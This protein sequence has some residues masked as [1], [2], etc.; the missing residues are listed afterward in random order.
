MENEVVATNGGEGLSQDEAEKLLAGFDP[1]YQSKKQDFVSEEQES[2]LTHILT[3]PDEIDAL[4]DDVADAMYAEGNR[5]FCKGGYDY[6][7]PNSTHDAEGKL[8]E[9]VVNAQTRQW[10]S[11]AGLKQM[12]HDIVYMNAAFQ[13]V[14]ALG[15]LLNGQHGKRIGM[16]AE[17]YAS[18]TFREKAKA[19]KDNGV[20]KTTQGWKAGMANWWDSWDLY[21]STHGKQA[22]DK[23]NLL[24]Y[25]PEADVSYESCRWDWNDVDSEVQK[26]ITDEAV[27]EAVKFGFHSQRKNP[28]TGAI[29]KTDVDYK[30]ANAFAEAVWNSPNHV[31]KSQTGDIFS[32][33][34]S[35]GGYK[36]ELA[37]G[38]ETE[39][40]YRVCGIAESQNVNERNALNAIAMRNMFNTN[41]ELL[42]WYRQYDNSRKDNALGMFNRK[43]DVTKLL[44]DFMEDFR[45]YAK[46]D[47]ELT[48]E[49]IE[50]RDRKQLTFQQL[51]ECLAMDDHREGFRHM[52]G[53]MSRFF[54]GVGNTVLEFGYELGGLFSNSVHGYGK[55]FDAAFS[56][57]SKKSYFDRFKEWAEEDLRCVTA[58]EIYDQ[59]TVAGFIG[60]EAAKLF[61]FS[62]L[63]KA[64]TAGALVNTA[65]KGVNASGRALKLAG[66]EGFG[67][68]VK[69][70]GA[71]I[72]KFGRAAG[73]G[74]TVAMKDGTKGIVGFRKI[75]IPKNGKLPKGAVKIGEDYFVKDIQKV[76][77]GNF[78]Q[79]HNARAA[80]FEKD[81]ENAVAQRKE[82][83][84]QLG[85]KIGD[86]AALDEAF[87]KV[88][89]DIDKMESEIAKSVGSHYGAASQWVADIVNELPSVMTVSAA[90]YDSHLATGAYKIG[91]GFIKYDENGNPVRAKF[92]PDE[93]D[94]V[95]EYSV[96]DAAGNAVFLFKL[97]KLMKGI[98]DGRL[99]TQRIQQSFRNW[100]GKVMELQQRGEYNM[101]SGL[102]AM[103]DN[104]FR[105][106]GAEAAHLFA[107]GAGM[108]VTSTIVGN[109]EDI[110]LKRLRDP[111]YQASIQEY[112][113]QP[114]QAL[115]VLKSGFGMMVGG[116]AAGAL[117][118]AAGEVK[119]GQV[120]LLTKFNQL[121]QMKELDALTRDTWAIAA[122]IAHRKGKNGIKYD[123]LSTDPV[124]ATRQAREQMM[125]D[126]EAYRYVSD[127]TTKFISRVITSEAARL[128]GLKPT[129]GIDIIREDMRKEFGETYVRV[130]DGIMEHV[131]RVNP[132]RAEFGYEWM[133]QNLENQVRTR[134]EA[135]FAEF[136]KHA[137]ETM[138]GIE[139]ALGV[140]GRR[141]KMRGDGSFLLN[142]DVD[143]K[144]GWL[145]LEFKS[146]DTMKAAKIADGQF[147]KGWAADVMNGL[148]GKDETFD[149]EHYGDLK[150]EVAALD[151]TLQE[152][153]K[154]GSDHNGI[155]ERAY[156]RICDLGSN[157]GFF[158]V[159]ADGKKLATMSNT[160]GKLTIADFA[161]ETVHGIIET[162]RDRGYFKAKDGSD[163]EQ[164]L[165]EKYGDAW[166][167]DFIRDL[168]T[169]RQE[170]EANALARDGISKLDEGGAFS[171][172]LN[173]INKVVMLPSELISASRPKRSYVESA[174][175]KFIEDAKTAHQEAVIDEKATEIGEEIGENTPKAEA[176]GGPIVVST[177]PVPNEIFVGG[178]KG[179]ELEARKR[180]LNNSGFYYDS[181]H[182]VW[183]N[184]KSAPTLYHRAVNEAIAVKFQTRREKN[185][186]LF[187]LWREIEGGKLQKEAKVIAI[188]RVKELIRPEEFTKAERDH[189]GILVSE[190]GS[191]IGIVNSNDGIVIDGNS[192][193]PIDGTS[194]PRG[195]KILPYSHDMYNR[196]SVKAIAKTSKMIAAH[197]LPPEYAIKM[198][199]E[200]S[201]AG[202]SLGVQ[203]KGQLHN[204]PFGIVTFMFGKKSID[205]KA[206]DDKGRYLNYLFDRDMGLPVFGDIYNVDKNGNVVRNRMQGTND[207][208]ADAMNDDGSLV[209]YDTNEKVGEGFATWMDYDYE[210][211][212]SK[213]G[214]KAR[215]KNIEKLRAMIDE[216]GNLSAD[217]DLVEF[218]REGE[219]PYLY[220]EGK[221]ARLVSSGEI[222]GV[223]I[224][225][226][227]E[228][229]KAKHTKSVEELDKKEVARVARK[230]GVGVDLFETLLKK[231]LHGGEYLSEE[232]E[233]K[234]LHEIVVK[235]VNSQDDFFSALDKVA[236]L[237]EKNG[238]PVDYWNGDNSDFTKVVRGGGLEEQK[239][240][241]ESVDR[242][243]SVNQDILFN[244]VGMRGAARYFGPK[245]NEVMDGIRQV[246]EDAVVATDDGTRAGLK[247]S[248]N[249]N[250]N[251]WL[252]SRA[253]NNFGPFVLH[254]GGTDGDK[255]PRLEYAGKKPK[256]PQAFLKRAKDGEAF[257][258]YDIMGNAV[259]QDEVLAKAYP[260]IMNAEVVF[261]GTKG[262]KEPAWLDD[263][264]FILAN[265]DGKIVINRDRYDEFLAPEQFAQSLVGLIQKAEG[266]E[267]RLRESDVK[268]A[269]A[270]QPT[271]AKR[272]NSR[273]SFWL[274]DP[275]FIAT[276]KEGERIIPVAGKLVER[277][278]RERLGDKYDDAV[279]RKVGSVI[280]E[281]IKNSVK[282]FAGE[283]EAKFLASRYGMKAEQ[284]M[285][286]SEAEKV[287]RD[288]LVTLDSDLT[289]VQ[290]TKKNIAY[291]ENVIG[292]A[293]DLCLFGKKRNDLT[294]KDRKR[295][296]TIRP[297]LR[298]AIADEMTEAIIERI[299]EGTRAVRTQTEAQMSGVGVG[300]KAERV[301]N[302]NEAGAYRGEEVD[303]S[304]S[305]SEESTAG[306]LAT[307][308]AMMS[309]EAAWDESSGGRTLATSGM[310]VVSSV[311]AGMTSAAKSIDAKWERN[312][313]AVAK[314][315]AD[316]IAKI[317]ETLRKDPSK[318]AS[319][320]SKLMDKLNGLVAENCSTYDPVVQKSMLNEAISMCGS[321]FRVVGSRR[322]PQE[323]TVQAASVKLA[324]EFMA[325]RRDNAVEKVQKWVEEQSYRIGIINAKRTAFVRD[326]MVAAVPVAERLTA[327]FK[328]T[329]DDVSL[330]RESERETAV[331]T[332]TDKILRGAV[333]G[334][335]L[336]S[337][338][339]DAASR[340]VSEAK[341]IQV[342]EVKNARGM[343]LNELNGLL[344]GDIVK[345]IESIGT[346]FGDGNALATKAIK[347]FSDKLR[348]TDSRFLDM[349]EDEF[350]QSE[351]ARAELASTVAAWLQ[352][353]SRRLGW[354]QVREWSMREA[355]RLQKTPQTFASIHMTMAKHAD[356]L[357]SSIGQESV[358]KL[359]DEVD[360][361]IDKYADGDRVAAM[362]VPN[363]DRKVA[364]RLQDYWKYVKQVMRMTEAAVEKEIAK[365]NNEL[366][367]S[368]MQLL[369]LGEK[370]ANDIEAAEEG[371]IARD[372][373]MMRLNALTRFGAMKHKSYAE[374]RDIID[375]QLTHD[376]AGS[377]QRQMILKNAR[378]E[379]DARVRQALIGELT[380]IRNAKKGKFDLPD[381]GTAGGNML[382]FSVAD[383][384]KRMQIYLHEGT[385]AWNFIDQFRQDMSLANIDKTMFVSNW[386]GEMR[387]ACQQIYGVNFERL[388]SDMMV[389][390]PAYDEFSRSGWYIPENGETVEVNVAGRVKKVVLAKQGDGSVK[391]NL[392]NH[393]SK[394]NLIY[395]YAACQ[396][397]DMQVNNAIWGR[398]AEYLR[399]IE[400]IIGPEGV[401]MAGWLTKAYGEIRK[402]I[403][404]I[405]EEITGMPVLSPDERYCPLSFTQDQVSNDERRFS[406]SPYPAF[407]TRRVTHD[408][409]RL[410]EQ[411]DAFRMFEDKIQDAGHYLG[412]AK[413][414]DRMNTTLKHP[415]VQTAFA[416]LYGTKA[417]NDIYAQLADALNGGRKNS[418]T[419]L[420]GV[421]NFVTATS[422]FGN[423]GS[424]MKQLEGIGGWAV[425]M[426]VGEWVRGLVRNPATSRE[427]RDGLRELIEAGLFQTREEEGIS[428]AMVSLMN[429]CDGVPAG[430]MSKT[431]RWY[432]RHGM[433]VTKFV[434]KIAS[435]SMAGQYYVGRKNFYI[436]NGVR[437][438]DAKRKALA[439]TDYAIQTTQQ[440]G[441]PEFLH[442]AQ[443]AGT[444]G[445]MLTQFSGPAFVRWGI[446]CET[447]HRAVV[448]GDKGAW[449]RLA[450]RLIALHLICPS[451]LTL[452]GGISSVIFRR[453]DQ[454]M[455][456][457]VDQTKKNIVANCITGP[458]SGWFIWGQII[459]AF[460]YENVMPDVKGM[461]SKTHFEAPV[462]SK[463]HSLQQMTSKMYK[464]V[465]KAAPWDRFTK[466]ERNLIR[467][468]TWRIFQM[469]FPVT[470]TA[471]ALNMVK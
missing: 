5:I 84:A 166:E 370:D 451:I 358:N 152:L 48:P 282:D 154:N 203:P 82:M 296:A 423:V 101:A 207:E 378:L 4:D 248:K 163:I 295:E 280:F 383:L 164:M 400:D 213:V 382:A 132:L 50:I 135:G 278:L 189:L 353:T 39:N 149:D 181:Q 134:K 326:V 94:V 38:G 65:G 403:S 420:C 220:G 376:L 193:Y 91:E 58:S 37:R 372:R 40:C 298:E 244:V 329:D 434:D 367:L 138:K 90:M 228:E 397:A 109:A 147:D 416:Q 141:P 60:G 6:M 443:R 27:A 399:K 19:F 407:L 427:V 222:I 233:G 171:K 56:D 188:R 150:R 272:M 104:G 431:Y 332:L 167:E 83:A 216:G 116:L 110:A 312:K 226:F 348:T 426:G 417:K 108:A 204:S 26:K 268:V 301:L 465:V 393:L 317:R 270:L 340:A 61:A 311:D 146:G 454:K 102:V 305:M 339:E 232:F 405:S 315:V 306:R 262:V 13:G 28:E 422:L 277:A 406:S 299:L 289:S 276:V 360:K 99:G 466:A 334:Y 350:E 421:R 55:M 85:G 219:L 346:T 366:K 435:M 263:K 290:Q 430:P 264:T 242:L 380:S 414:I 183:V 140:K 444:A 137:K 373:A 455:K 68:N 136:S 240:R 199:E 208:W 224:P 440:S 468:D 11:K 200:G 180:E 45:P 169:G 235:K 30:D 245:A 408:S 3:H 153:L 205:L 433:D 86:E 81:L 374:C 361:S 424:A 236:E 267:G 191:P 381:N 105:R 357:A 117:S 97:N 234:P 227:S 34:P 293:I 259:R 371:L 323:L 148:L 120:P 1:S 297:E 285:D 254:I 160:D 156:E 215:I 302:L 404:P 342:R 385:E 46:N 303:G 447:L 324:K 144:N 95:K 313:G 178:L 162:L 190:N 462:L 441:R 436:E 330:I 76:K 354:G 69:S 359:L 449:S 300:E 96:Y 93:W 265:E 182:D 275:R 21:S 29:E 457:L 349:T 274:S 143:G 292:K 158:S 112:L 365:Y 250:L 225:R 362:N 327:R 223:S 18:A 197:C 103:L 106:K 42:K 121:R 206:K 459:N 87:G 333:G 345:D 415:K 258:V 425:E 387:K 157:T 460:A 308:F 429:S 231:K 445:K 31:F 271:R 9:G 125:R 119:N 32:A 151:A 410:N 448:M 217:P 294:H 467:E 256:M 401:A 16:T 364:P 336:G 229:Y 446:E 352:E 386:E 63:M 260:E 470:R 118:G 52:G 165:R 127:K 8:F 273:M 291:W 390:N 161:H 331:Q 384:F 419:L 80:K 210:R 71:A 78:M 75:D 47:S 218:K 388:V 98:L 113:V 389:K 452:A 320:Q 257:H 123:E 251:D 418:D 266:W 309:D 195:S 142:F 70:I 347:A 57:D 377:I 172:L 281:S 398:D 439:D 107:T 453:E 221:L 126:E 238:I 187:K 412:F 122:G 338:G 355:A 368:D 49:E 413:I 22:E 463:L 304:E 288:T 469:L 212:P 396:Q 369:E 129:E 74:T 392:P 7:M 438:E 343:G 279:L 471:N 36:I 15:Q 72:Q 192:F 319:I 115:G 394:A 100:Y 198:L 325:G 363:Y 230:L 168:L 337:S 92:N 411:C 316:E 341:R 247:S 51:C 310:T 111:E 409:L 88:Y 43:G 179:D 214:R 321:K 177:M 211:Y 54:A 456:D 17:Q 73:G 249:A 185:A 2:Q 10:T 67:Q 77:V 442:S 237:C 261:S 59:G 64:S 284:L 307:G 174:L 318:A 246:I 196:W 14:D 255:K 24:K 131:R 375:A 194:F 335:N 314:A 12:A 201:S 241:A 428:E 184:E 128:S 35:K 239:L 23:E 41:P 173:G 44:N 458:M 464:D 356:R 450:S 402:R 395:I 53:A 461:A 170:L 322:T 252:A 62:A 25:G 269:E 145:N 344:G 159:T 328:G 176:V 66:L 130:M 351:V 283:A 287:L 243:S 20:I 437:E 286:Y 139:E 202:L 124:I 79:E 391:T 89:A 133:R 155:L 253:N 114:E 186:E 209:R 379:D 175:D 33:I 432:K